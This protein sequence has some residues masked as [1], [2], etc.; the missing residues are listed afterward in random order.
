MPR[1]SSAGDQ[2]AEGLA[3]HSARPHSPVRTC[4]GCRTRDVQANLVR[5][6]ARDSV[7]VV[8]LRGSAPGRGAYVHPSSDC[9]GQASRRRAWSRALKVSGPVTDTEA[10]EHIARNPKGERA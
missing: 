10:V 3:L 2:A 7:L 6:V 9:V 1:L 4:L 5:V 8:D